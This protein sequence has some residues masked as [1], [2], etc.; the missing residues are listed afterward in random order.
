MKDE[1]L[2]PSANTFQRA[3]QGVCEQFACARDDL[4]ITT[5]SRGLVG[6]CLII[7]DA[8][9][10]VYDCRTNPFPI[11]GDVNEIRRLHCATT[12]MAGNGKTSLT[13]IRL[14]VVEKET[15]FD[16]L[17]QQRFFSANE[18]GLPCV[19]VTGRG[20]PSYSTRAFLSK[21]IQDDEDAGSGR[22]GR[23]SIVDVSC[24]TDWNVDGVYI[25]LTYMRG[26]SN[27]T[28]TTSERAMRIPS[29]RWLGLHFE[30][31]AH[32]L[33][34]VTEG[35]SSQTG[36]VTRLAQ[37]DRRKLK[38]LLSDPD[39]LSACDDVFRAGGS[40]NVQGQFFSDRRASAPLVIAHAELQKMHDSDLKCE[41]EAL[42]R[43]GAHGLSFKD[44]IRMM[45]L[46]TFRPR[47]DV[48][49]TDTAE[50]P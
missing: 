4:F 14:V 20:Y 44:M 31:I 2:F 24:I 7:T 5:T 10:D 46:D 25:F 12:T 47:S 23:G 32:I 18:G 28:A 15:V 22:N 21:V 33:W 16:V 29:M 8:N 41:I 26:G 13:P 34:S 37:N 27:R 3:V 49:M 1:A 38:N 9:G 30:H 43:G 6:G 40:S 11:P 39:L 45:I 19:L 17:M 42:M 48:P 36:S 35:G 50:L